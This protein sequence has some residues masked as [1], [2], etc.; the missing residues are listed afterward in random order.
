MKKYK[1]N[2]YL[3]KYRALNIAF[4]MF[5]IT[6]VPE[7]FK[8]NIWSMPFVWSFLLSLV[9]AT[10]SYFLYYFYLTKTQHGRQFLIKANA[11]VKRNYDQT[12]NTQKEES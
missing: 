9:L 2:R 8:F 6:I 7:V 5:I 1:K 11:E 3:P 12:H 10:I 4:M